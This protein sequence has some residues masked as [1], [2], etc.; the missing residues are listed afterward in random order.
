V[1]IP[2]QAGDLVP[3]SVSIGLVRDRRDKI[4]GMQMVANDITARKQAESIST[5]QAEELRRSNTEL[6]QFA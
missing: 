4:I 2:T 1:E 6:E 3:L 5:R